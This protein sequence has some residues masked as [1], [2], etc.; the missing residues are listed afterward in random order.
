MAR[1]DGPEN[2]ARHIAVMVQ[3]LHPPPIR[4]DS[5]VVERH[6]EGVRVSGSNPFLGANSFLISGQAEGLH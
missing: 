2:R 1:T 3:F 5:S 4:R 6:V